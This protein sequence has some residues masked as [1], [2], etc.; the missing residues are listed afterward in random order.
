MPFISRSIGTV[1]SL[2]TSSAEWPG[3]WAV[4]ET[5]GGDRSG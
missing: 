1:I 4:I 3:H 2:S 5:I